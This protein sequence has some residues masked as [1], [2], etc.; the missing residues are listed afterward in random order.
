MR[1]KTD[2]LMLI[3]SPVY[4]DVLGTSYLVTPLLGAGVHAGIEVCVVEDDGIGIEH[5]PDCRAAA[6]CQDTAEQLPVSVKPLH[7]LLQARNT[8][9]INTT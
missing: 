3:M 2:F 8:R 6:V 1:T 7:A 4:V 5:S 9:H